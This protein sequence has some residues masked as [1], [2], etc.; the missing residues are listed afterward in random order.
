MDLC[1]TASDLTVAANEVALALSV[2][3][4]VQ[5]LPLHTLCALRHGPAL[6]HQLCGL[7]VCPV[8]RSALVP[9]AQCKSN[10]VD[11]VLVE[12][13]GVV[14]GELGWVGAARLRSRL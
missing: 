11:A 7:A 12:E 5:N 10:K 13:G 2:V 1:Q 4:E 8:C 14:G 6:P 3:R 9:A